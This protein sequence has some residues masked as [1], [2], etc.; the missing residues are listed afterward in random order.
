MTKK[1][2]VR[3]I[4]QQPR[5]SQQLS[6]GRKHLRNPLCRVGCSVSKA[7]LT[8]QICVFP[9]EPQRPLRVGP[10]LTRQCRLRE[11]GAAHTARSGM[12]TPVSGW[13]SGPKAVTVRSLHVTLRHVTSNHCP[14]SYQ[15][16]CIKY[17]IKLQ[18]NR[19]DAPDSPFMNSDR[20]PRICWDAYSSAG[21]RRHRGARVDVNTSAEALLCAAL[22]LATLHNPLRSAPLHR[23]GNQGWRAQFKTSANNSQQTR[24]PRT[25]KHYW[26]KDEL[27]SKMK[28]L[29]P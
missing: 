10:C 15:D 6:K 23:C 9:P 2:S 4:T 5:G 8:D 17:S 18:K 26:F 21:T 29:F 3:S 27:C 12:R 11:R 1:L 19:L 16:F 24:G 7:N 20:H 22:P 14:C 25:E 13:I 28:T